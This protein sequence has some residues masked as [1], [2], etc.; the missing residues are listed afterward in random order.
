MIP[1]R[2]ASLR[3][4]ALATTTATAMAFALLSGAGSAASTGSAFGD[5]QGSWG[6]TGTVTYKS[7]TKERLR[8]RVQ[9]TQAGPN[10]LQQALRCA[11]DSY[12]FQINAYY[13]HSS[14]SLSGRWDELVM[15]LKGTISGS[16]DNGSINGLLHG[17]GFTA[18]VSVVTTGTKQI[19]NIDAPPDQ[20]ITNVSIQVSK[21]GR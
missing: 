9:Y 16:L 1:L 13:K 18:N 2:A 3:R 14:G 17:P 11:S 8:C 20:D 5:L 7:G 19:V 12:K 10:D 6:G 21:G 4:R 15:N